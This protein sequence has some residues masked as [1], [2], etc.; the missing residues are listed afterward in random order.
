MPQGVEFGTTGF[1]AA[2]SGAEVARESEE[3]GFDVQLFG[4]NHAMAPDV[5]GE[6]RAAAEATS[7]IRLL[8]GP[9]NFV[10][11]DPG[12]IASSIAAVQIASAGRAICGVAIAVMMSSF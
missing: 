5:F 10:T 1:C 3:L 7:K 9:V 12:V 6:M 4:E 2:F 8:C 11:R